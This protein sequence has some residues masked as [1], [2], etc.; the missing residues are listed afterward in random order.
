[1]RRAH[2]IGDPIITR[3]EVSGSVSRVCFRDLYS[4]HQAP[5]RGSHARRRLA[6]FW[7]PQCFIHPKGSNE[8]RGRR[9]CVGSSQRKPLQNVELGSRSLSRKIDTSDLHE[10][11]SSLRYAMHPLEPRLSPLPSPPLPSPP[12]WSTY[13]TYS[14]SASPTT[15][16][17]SFPI[18][19]ILVY[20]PLPL[21]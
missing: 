17:I 1:M 10:D 19:Q 21:W 6:A 13:S 11:Q 12:P 5:G 4:K 18:T 3:C 14:G 7:N 15:Y 16:V 8:P 2:Q 20:L 9:S